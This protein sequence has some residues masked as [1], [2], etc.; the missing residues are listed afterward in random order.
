MYLNRFRLIALAV[1]M[2]CGVA[3]S[4][5]VNAANKDSQT[6]KTSK[7]TTKATTKVEVKK[8]AKSS[9]KSKAV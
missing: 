9:K 2:S 6:A 8:V 1:L 3:A 7:P 5:Q 4:F